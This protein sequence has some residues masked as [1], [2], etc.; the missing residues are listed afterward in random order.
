MEATLEWFRNQMIEHCDA[1]LILVSIHDPETKQ[2]HKLY[3][4]G[5]SVHAQMG[6][7]FDF[8]MDSWKA[9]YNE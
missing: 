7:A 1:C 3:D 9:G 2:S 8:L 4:G 6:M 5:G